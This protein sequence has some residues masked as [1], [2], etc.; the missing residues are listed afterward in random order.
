MPEPEEEVALRCPGFT[1]WNNHP[2]PCGRPIHAAP[3]HDAGPVCLMHSKDPKKDSE[4]FATECKRLLAEGEEMVANFDGFVF[5][6]MDFSDIEFRTACSFREATFMQRADFSGAK[7]AQDAD[8]WRV[9]FAQDA[10]FE[11]AAFMQEAKFFWATFTEKVDFSNATFTQ[12][13]NFRLS[14]FAKSTSFNGATFMEDAGFGDVTFAHDA[15]F[16]RAEFAKKA[17]FGGTTFKRKANF[18]SVKFAHNAD[19]KRTIF[20]NNT[21]FS[22]VTFT[23][24]IDFRE[25]NFA[26][27]ASFRGTTFM[28][29]AFFDQAIFTQNANF[30]HV[31]FKKSV[32]FYKVKFTQTADFGWTSCSDEVWF[33]KTEFRDDRSEKIGLNLSDARLLHPEK[34]EFYDNN[35]GQAVFFNTDVSKIDFTLV[36]WRERSQGKHCLFDENVGLGSEYGT[37]A[38]KPPEGSYDERNYALIAETYQ[39]LKRNYDAKGDYWTAGHFHYGEMEMLRLHSERRLAPLR[40]LSRNLSLT[41]LYKYASAY[42]ESMGK[43]LA[44]LVAIALVFAL[45]FPLAGLEV[46]PKPGEAGLAGWQVDYWNAGAFFQQHPVENPAPR[47][48]RWVT[49]DNAAV[50]LL[51]H[52]GMTALSVAGFQKELRYSPAYPWGR[53][54]ALLELLLTTTLGGLFLLTIRRQYKRS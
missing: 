39:Q 47:W 20:T 27:N 44:W 3:E 13:A 46:N 21:D 5:P 31:K 22:S 7:F 18:S 33:W 52:S 9:T 16:T 34:I 8:F 6:S 19:F 25:A 51:V 41:A 32:N 49:R 42:G 26:Q 40:W 54:L 1:G 12:A 4:A 36:R 38:L 10:D 29:D 11:R 14:G 30:R 23:Q 45:L 53:A 28:E 2:S 43:P 48:V 50:P 37:D 35:L 24:N 15:D 17:Y